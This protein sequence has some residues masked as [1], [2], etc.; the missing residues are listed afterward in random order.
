MPKATHFKS[1]VVK[2]DPKTSLK[3][4]GIN[5]LTLPNGSRVVALGHLY[6]PH[7]DRSMVEVVLEYLRATKPAVVF[8]LGGIVDEEAFKEFGEDQDNYLHQASDAPEVLEALEAGG[9][10][11]AAQLLEE[12][13]AVGG[14]AHVLEEAIDR[15][16]PE[17]D[18]FHVKRRHG[19]AERFGFVD[20]PGAVG[21]SRQARPSSW[22]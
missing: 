18:A 5:T 2:E 3:E 15:V 1:V 17:A 6:F 12:R 8:L 21:V 19:A 22:K 13:A 14:I 10:E 20:E 9:F 4:A 11:V 16:H 7:H